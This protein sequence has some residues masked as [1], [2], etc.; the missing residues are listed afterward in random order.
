MK[1][2]I[3]GYSGFLGNFLCESLSKKFEITKV[4]LRNIP[5]Q[6][7]NSFGLFFDQF[8]K[9]DCIINCAASLKPKSKDDIFINQDF[10]SILTNYLKKIKK[11][12]S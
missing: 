6:S 11:I 1:V 5:E 7:S 9:A 3:T 4:N 12:F 2:I 10:P 8:L